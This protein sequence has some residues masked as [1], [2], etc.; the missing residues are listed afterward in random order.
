MFDFTLR[1]MFR[2]LTRLALPLLLFLPSASRAEFCWRSSSGRGVGTIPTSCGDNQDNDAG[3]CYPRCKEGYRGVG[4]VCWRD[5]PEGFSDIGV[6]CSKPAAYGR[7]AGYPWKFGD[8]LDDSGMFSRCE[9]DN[10]SG[11]CEKS[12]LIVYPKCKP[13]FHPVGCCVCSPDCPS[14]FTDSGVTCTKPSFGRGV[15]TIPGCGS[16]LQ[17]DAGLCYSPCPS[18]FTGVGPVCWGG[19]P[20]SA[21]VNCGAGCAASSG[22]CSKAVTGQVASVL[23]VA[24]NIAAAVASGGTSAAGKVTVQQGA[25]ATVGNLAV[26]GMTKE[27]IKRKL[28]EMAADAGQSITEAQA[29]NAV[30]ALAG[31]E[32]DP[33]T[34]DPTGISGIINAYKSN[35]CPKE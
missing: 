34:L 22:E 24:I 13:G 25:K 3:L 29:N 27:Q 30:N 17:Y 9:R 1:A 12:G 5:C 20:A 19:C 31:E 6:G 28:L 15:G 23:E 14:D 32:F 33:T 35:I 18:G 16:S 7:G 8:A 11:G 4:P 26:K 10:G 21:P 2:I